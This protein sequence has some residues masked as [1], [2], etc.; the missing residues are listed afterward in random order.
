D[1]FRMLSFDVYGPKVLA[2]IAGLPPVLASRCIPIM[3]FRAGENSPKPKRR[4]DEDPAE[5]QS[6]CDDLH[7]LALEHGPTWIELAQDCDV[8]PAGINARN[9]ELWQ[10]LLVLA[11]WIED[12]GATGLLPLMQKVALDS[13]RSSVDDQ[14]PDVDETLLEL[15]AD[16]IQ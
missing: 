15:L 12:R 11:R 6:L 4:I 13:V 9:L 14:I 1:S 8:C 7:A 5:W 10:P 3:M 2:C 16:A